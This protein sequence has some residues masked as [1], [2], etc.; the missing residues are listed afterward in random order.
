MTGG[1]GGDFLSANPQLNPRFHNW[2]IAY[3]KYCDGASFS[4]NR[5]A[6]VPVPGTNTSIY[7]RGA[8]VFQAIF[9]S[10]VSDQ[11]MASAN[12]L[13]LSGCSAG[14]LATYLHCD[15]FAELAFEASKASVTNSK[16]IGSSSSLNHASKKPVVKCVADAG[17]FANIPSLFGTPPPGADNPRHSIIEYEYTW[18]FTQQQSNNSKIGVNQNCLAAMGRGNPLCFFP[19]HSLEHMDTPMFVLNSGYDSW[20]TNFIWFTPDGGKPHDQ[21]WHDCAQYINKCNASQLQIMD[22]YHSKF[23]EKLAPMMS[24]TTLHGGFVDSCMAHCQSGGGGTKIDNKT[25]LQTIADWY[26]G[27]DL[28]KRIDSPYPGG[29]CK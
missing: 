10:L 25:K 18:V 29:A 15:A 20:Q 28:A 6:P 27:K 7:F 23:V 4:G 14:G 12:E 24:A 22:T 16:S 17:Y 3:A 1:E 21:G 8:R 9:D 5:S 26:D 13:L 11:G 2:N 19:E